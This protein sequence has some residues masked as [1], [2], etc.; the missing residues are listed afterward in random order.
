MIFRTSSSSSSSAAES[1]RKGSAR[2]RLAPII[3]SRS[4]NVR[5]SLSNAPILLSGDAMSTSS[6]SAWIFF[7]NKGY[8]NKSRI[9]N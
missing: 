2:K 8:I 4:E 3:F 1:G 9:I 6:T 7:Q 5:V